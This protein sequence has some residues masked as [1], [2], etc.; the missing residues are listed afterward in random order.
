MRKAE[1][2]G[3]VRIDGLGLLNGWIRARKMV[4]IGTKASCRNA[5]DKE[6]KED[7]DGLDAVSWKRW[8]DWD[9]RDGG[10]ESEQD[11]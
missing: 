8:V 9:E 3:G 7:E 6:K 4:G 5:G 10:N 1:V 2:G 11:Q